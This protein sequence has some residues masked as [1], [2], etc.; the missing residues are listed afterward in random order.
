[1]KRQR[2]QE[3]HMNEMQII[4]LH[5]RNK[6][7]KTPQLKKA[8]NSPGFIEKECSSDGEQKPKKVSGSSDRKKAA[9]K[10]GKKVKKALQPKKTPISPEF[11]ETDDSSEEEEEGLPKDENGEKIPPLLG[12]KEEVQS[13]LIFRRIG[14]F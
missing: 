14:K 13:F 10:A 2:Y 12:V 9:A 4:N 7:R 11:I 5:K 1:M 6:A 3:G 8:P